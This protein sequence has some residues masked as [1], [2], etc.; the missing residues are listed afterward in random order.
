MTL[1]AKRVIRDD[2]I[3]T[4]YSELWG[5][6]FIRRDYRIVSSTYAPNTLLREETIHISDVSDDLK[7]FLESERLVSFS[8]SSNH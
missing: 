8:T 6:W 7:A 5:G 3:Y 1:G 2:D 4:D